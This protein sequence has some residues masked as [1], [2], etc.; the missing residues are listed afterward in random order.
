[1]GY[2]GEA[3][4]GIDLGTQSVRV[5]L[6]TADGTVLGR[7]SA[8]LGGHREGERHEQD[9]EE[10]WA[11][12]CAASRQALGGVTGVRI[13]GLAVC[14]TSGTVESSL[15][16]RAARPVLWTAATMY[17]GSIWRRAPTA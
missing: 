12:V 4:L 7:G 13:V 15:S 1:M 5:L 6:V 16:N 14:G 17:R 11:G 2:E 3:W 9:P 10:W 8:P